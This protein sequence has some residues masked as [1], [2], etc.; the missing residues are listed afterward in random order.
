M[1]AYQIAKVRRDPI[2]HQWTCHRCIEEKP[3]EQTPGK[4]DAATPP[5]NAEDTNEDD[6]EPDPEIQVRV[7]SDEGS[8]PVAEVPKSN[9]PEICEAKLSGRRNCQGY[10]KKSYPPYTCC[11]TGC[12][13]KCHRTP[14]CSGIPRG[15]AKSWKCILHKDPTVEIRCCDHCGHSLNTQSRPRKCAEAGCKTHVHSTWLCSGIRGTNLTTWCCRIHRKETQPLPPPP[16]I[17]IPPQ[18]GDPVT[19]KGC[20]KKCRRDTTPFYCKECKGPYHQKCTKMN[21]VQRDMVRIDPIKHQWTCQS[22]IKKEEKKAELA[23]E[24]IVEEEVDEQTPGKAP[25]QMKSSLRILQWNAE[26]VSGKIFELTN[27]LTE[28]EFDVCLIQESRLKVHATTPYIK[29]YKTIRSDRVGA[30]GGGLLAFVKTSL[31]VEE[32]GVSAIEGTEISSFRI[33]LSKKKWVNF[34]NVYIPPLDLNCKA[35]TPRLDTIPALKSS[36]ICGD[37]NAHSALWDDNYITD[38][39]GETLV[40]W[41]FN[42]NLTILNNGTSTR[43][44]RSTG[45][46]SA[47]DVSLCGSNWI[48]KTEWQV[49][50][51]IGSSDHLPMIITVKSDTLHQSVYGKTARWRTNGAD[52]DKY[53]DEVSRLL[54]ETDRLS[55]TKRIAKFTSNMI[56]AAKLHVKRAK[57]G[58]RAKVSMNPAIRT[59][60]GKR[61]RLRRDLKN[62][63]AEWLEACKDVNLAIKEARAESWKEVIEGVIEEG[64]DRKVW[65]FINTLNGTPDTNSP[66]EVMVHKGK[67]ITSGTGKANCFVDHY[68]EV[69]T[70]KWQ[71]KTEKSTNRKRS[72]LLA[73]HSVDDSNS[74]DF[75]M[76]ELKTALKKMRRKGA[77]GPDDIPPSFLIELP[78]DALAILL[79]IYNESYRSANCPQI[80]RSAIIIPLLKAGKPPG[81]VKSYRPVSLT[82]CVVKLMERMFADRI[83]TIMETSESFSRL[84]AGFRKGRS[85]EDQ[86]LKITQAIENGFMKKEFERSLLVLLDYSAAFDKVW[87]QRL[88]ETMLDQGIPQPIVRWIDCFLSNRQA[89]VR[90]GDNMSRSRTF[91]QGLPQG[92]VLSPLLF[93]IYINNLAK[94]LSDTDTVVMFADDVGI[95]VTRRE[96]KDAEVRA[97]ELV[98]IVVK[99]SKKWKLTLNPIKSEVST[100]TS[101]QTEVS[102]WRPTIK[103]N[104]TAIPFNRNPR[105]LGVILDCQLSFNIHVQHLSNVLAG[106]TKVIYAVSNSEWGWDRS[107][108]MKLHSALILGKLNYA[109]CA[110][111]PWLSKSMIDKL[112]VIV[113]KSLRTITGMMWTTPSDAVRMETRQPS[114]HTTIP[115]MCLQSVEKAQRMPADHPLAVTWKDAVPTK[116]ERISWKSQADKL[117][118]LIPTAA[119][120]R[121]P[122]TFYQRPPWKSNEHVTIHCEMPGISGKHDDVSKIKAASYARINS[123]G[124]DFTIYTDGSATGGTI[125]GGAGVVVT[126]GPAEQPTVLETMTLRGAPLTSSYEEEFSAAMQAIRWISSA[127]AINSDSLVAIVTD[128]QSLCKALSSWN[129]GVDHLWNAMDDIPCKIIWQWL[130]GHSDVEGNELADQAAKRAT[131]GEDSPRP[132]S[133]NAIKAEIRNIVPEAP[134]THTRSIDVYS[135]WS[136]TAEEQVTN[137]ADRV[138]LAQLRSGRHPDLMDTRHRFNTAE[139]PA[140]PRCEHEKDDVTHWLQCPGTMASRMKIFGK[141]D[142]DVS[143]LTEFPKKSIALARSTL[144]G[145]KL[146][147]RTP[148][149]SPPRG[150]DVQR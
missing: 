133:I 143:V 118:P 137:R 113:N 109:A 108:L 142:L 15:V 120:S 23:K 53:R 138:Y 104:G 27:R 96:A 89:K 97:Q 63:K 21:I 85:C 99:W 84:Q 116:N 146:L 1:S 100:F 18:E 82:S 6:D 39:R 66:N 117:L 75:S 33:Q 94:E 136:R 7:A 124:S 20:R 14:H 102:T 42:N 51:P 16:P 125:D 76:K 64:D 22:C 92:S 37:F 58:K 12:A 55:L 29:G 48:G 107:S 122:I 105:L 127:P 46:L 35:F 26:A 139:T 149:N 130:P 41:I 126:C 80:W 65:Q 134:P 25:E 50:E 140:C 88:L 93:I 132:V 3:D 131:T 10:F 56:E 69:S 9:S 47:P 129:S 141:T 59:K 68:A 79:E 91:S 32:L 144:R 150:E 57:P 148:T 28:D 31:V 4:R 112:D 114:Y 135:K 30:F 2:I 40:D 54:P 81:A 128:S 78:D 24:I 60:I 49:G 36:I 8:E 11:H 145:A 43:V 70:L 106:K 86:I 71:N 111:Q 83:Y 90:Y 77:P 13:V 67:R 74:Q 123:F 73:T 72:E 115:R 95:L 19:C 98:D 5:T 52:W 34:A 121:E 45:T 38:D 87:R 110:W 61:N 101:L 44:H 103:I 119:R 147:E 62:N 17:T